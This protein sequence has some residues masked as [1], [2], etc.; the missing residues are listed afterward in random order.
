MIAEY[1]RA[2]ILALLAVDAGA[3]DAEKERVTI[4]LTGTRPHGAIVRIADAARTLGVHRNTI[5]K[6]MRSGKLVAVKGTGDKAI[7][8][9]EESLAKF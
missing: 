3:T 5:Y 8:V 2:A 7:G 1:T 6:L 9:T 4:A